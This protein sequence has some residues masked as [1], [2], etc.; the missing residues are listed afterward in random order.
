MEIYTMSTTASTP[1]LGMP[2]FGSAFVCAHAVVRPW[3]Q[4]NE[5]IA[6]AGAAVKRGNTGDPA[7]RMITS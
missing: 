1:A 7:W 6:L 4:A 3:N 2:V 5:A